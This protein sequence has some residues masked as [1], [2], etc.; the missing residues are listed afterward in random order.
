MDAG[1]GTLKVPPL[2]R[3]VLIFLMTITAFLLEK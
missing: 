1:G 3:L 2:E